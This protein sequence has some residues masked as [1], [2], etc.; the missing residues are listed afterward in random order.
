MAFNDW[1]AELQEEQITKFAQILHDLGKDPGKLSFI[2]ALNQSTEL[3]LNLRQIEQ[4]NDIMFD[5]SINFLGGSNS[6]NFKIANST[7]DQSD[8]LKLNYRLDLPKNI[9][10]FNSIS[11]NPVLK[12]LFS[13]IAFDITVPNKLLGVN[14]DG[15]RDIQVLE[16]FPCT[17][18]TSRAQNKEN[19]SSY[20]ERFKDSAHLYTQMANFLVQMN[21]E[22]ATYSDMK[23]S[24]WLVETDKNGNLGNLRMADIK[25]LQPI[26]FKRSPDSKGQY[27]EPLQTT[28]YSSPDFKSQMDRICPSQTEAYMF[29]KNLYEFLAAANLTAVQIQDNMAACDDNGAWSADF[30]PDVFKTPQGEMYE[31]LIKASTQPQPNSRLS[32]T[33]VHECMKMLS[34][35]NV[36]Q[37]DFL[38]FVDDLSENNQKSLPKFEAFNIVAFY[39]KKGGLTQECELILQKIWSL[40]ESNP[41]AV[42]LNVLQKQLKESLKTI[43]LGVASDILQGANYEIELDKIYG[44]MMDWPKRFMD[45]VM[46]GEVFTEK[47]IEHCIKE[48]SKL[49]DEGFSK[50]IKDVKNYCTNVKEIEGQFSQLSAAIKSMEGNEDN[51]IPLINNVQQ[52]MDSFSPETQATMDAALK[53]VDDFNALA[54]YKP[55]P[56]QPITNLES[57]ASQLNA[58]EKEGQLTTMKSSMTQFRKEM[59]DLSKEGTLENEE[60]SKYNPGS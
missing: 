6:M 60:A 51:F 4:L 50:L 17:D 40:A 10:L 12:K 2:D 52:Q 47:A 31:K 1:L 22:G 34:M 25:S 5:C 35:P 58:N 54:T 59:A 15:A 8:I 9:E 44:N 38:K 28:G 32:I 36:N 24:N 42:E 16:Y 7:G 43:N 29:G 13:A 41:D 14:D 45:L 27:R 26:G 19:R 49:D 39:P 21:K 37:K 11:S 57:V 18:L 46:I 56:E 55:L 30:F 53:A 48:Q 20:Q 23:N 33:Q 3:N